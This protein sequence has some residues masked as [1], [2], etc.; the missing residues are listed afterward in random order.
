MSQ[1]CKKFCTKL[2]EIPQVFYPLHSL[3]I[4]L[5]ATYNEFALTDGSM[6]F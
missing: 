6:F 5:V 3:Y 2:S 1:L 4:M